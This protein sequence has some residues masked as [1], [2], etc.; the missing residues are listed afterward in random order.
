MTTYRDKEIAAKIGLGVVEYPHH[1]THEALGGDVVAIADTLSSGIVVSFDGLIANI[2]V[3]YV[4]CDGNNGTVNRLTRFEKQVD[5]AITEAGTT[6]GATSKTTGI[7]GQTPVNAD[8]DNAAIGIAASDD[9]THGITD[10]RP[11]YIDTLKLM[12]T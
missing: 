10:I 4:I 9:H 8:G 2:P 3:G 7:E 6:G 12:K 11:L 5:T 1:L